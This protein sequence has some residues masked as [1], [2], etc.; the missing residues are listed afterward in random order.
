M[1]Q[2]AQ[3][4]QELLNSGLTSLRETISIQTDENNVL[5]HKSLTPDEP[6]PAPSSN[7][8]LIIGSSIIRNF[9]ESKLPNHEVCCM[10]GAYM[11]DIDNKLKSLSQ[12]GSRFESITIVAGGNNASRPSED[13]NLETTVL[14][15]KA[16]IAGASQCR[17]M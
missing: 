3:S 5:K 9:D 4:R 6:A 11:K 2:T 7:R 13:V 8:C 17:Q 12:S 14:A 16:A 15:L 10:P 1:Q